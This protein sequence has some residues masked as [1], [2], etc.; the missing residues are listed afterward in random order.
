MMFRKTCSSW[1]GS[2]VTPGMCVFDLALDLDVVYLQ[3][4]IAQRQGL[5]QHPADIHLLLLRLALAG[6]RQQVLHHAVGALRLLEEFA[7]EV[8]GPFS[9]SPS[10]SSS[11]A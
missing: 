6:K 10:L 2:A 1:C 3:I 8:R 4:V 9:P 5:V 11:W 7:H